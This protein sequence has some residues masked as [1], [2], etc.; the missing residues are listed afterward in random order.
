MKRWMPRW[1]CLIGV[2]LLAVGMRSTGRAQSFTTTIYLPTLR[3]LNPC[4]ASPVPLITRPPTKQRLA[5]YHN[6]YQSPDTWDLFLTNADNTNRTRLTT[7]SATEGRPAWSPDGTRIAYVSSGGSSVVLKTMRLSDRRVSTVYTWPS[8]ASVADPAW[9]P[10]GRKIAFAISPFLYSGSYIGIIDTNGANL[11]ILTNGGT[12]G[13]PG[14]SPDGTR[15]VF[16]SARSNVSH[17]YV[18]QADGSNIAQLTNQEAWDFEPAWSPDGS[19]IAFTSGC[20]GAPGGGNNS[21]Y[22][23]QADGS[24]RMHIPI[25][26]QP[27]AGVYN[28][29]TQP[30][31]SPDGT[32]IAYTQGFF[33]GTAI[34]IV[35][36]DGSGFSVLGAS[37]DGGASWSPR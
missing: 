24:G 28:S 27:Q 17:L 1:A 20:I 18:M 16:S 32:Q 26:E 30:A 8:E 36:L 15:I 10:D 6:N 5:F 31:W 14:W 13:S 23:I 29:Q 4:A 19:R 25:P 21:I 12:D 35:N 3:Y 2:L 9:S 33:K 11:R 7:D 22:I 37:L 34:Y